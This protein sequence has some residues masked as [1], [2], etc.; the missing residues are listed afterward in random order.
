MP[1]RAFEDFPIGTRI[2]SATYLVSAEA[3]KAFAREFDPQ[4]FHLDEELA[5]GTV[6]GQLAASGWHTAAISMRLFVDAMKVA[7][8]II[9]MGVDELHWPAAVK[10]GDELRLEIEVLNARVSRSRP[11]FGI[12][13]INNVT[14]NQRA[15][16]VQSF[17]ASAMLPRRNEQG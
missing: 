5:A 9:G 11:A 16:T 8:G 15:E 7:G 12:L 6:F 2:L 3:I 10:A 13:K 14:R 4:L 17:I 1:S